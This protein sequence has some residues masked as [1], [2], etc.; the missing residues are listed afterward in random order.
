MCLAVLFCEFSP[1]PFRCEWEES[2]HLRAVVCL[3]FSFLLSGT[4]ALTDVG[5]K[6]IITPPS[7]M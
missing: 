1:N 3:E 5:G 7:L 6:C 2:L 4:S